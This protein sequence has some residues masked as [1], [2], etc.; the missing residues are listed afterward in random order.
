MSFPVHGLITITP[1]TTIMLNIIHITA[2]TA[3]VKA[4]SD[5]V[6]RCGKRAAIDLKVF[7]YVRL[8]DKK[9][10]ES[11]VERGE[12]LVFL[13]E[14][15]EVVDGGKQRAVEVDDETAV[16]IRLLLRPLHLLIIQHA[17]ALTNP[18][19]SSPSGRR[20]CA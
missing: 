4:R 19:L 3:S 15:E 6:D 16:F 8:E 2:P 14:H 10:G 9:S 18:G 1:L 7:E 12:G 17:V 20:T 11:R 5:F 13:E